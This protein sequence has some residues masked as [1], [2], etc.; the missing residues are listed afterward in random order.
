VC[1]KTCFVLWIHCGWASIR[2]SFLFTSD[3]EDFFAWG[4]CYDFKNIFAETIGKKLAILTL[5]FYPKKC[6]NIDF[7]ENRYFGRKVGHHRRK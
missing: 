4:R 6:H 7:Q 1:G 2:N 3:L 5:L